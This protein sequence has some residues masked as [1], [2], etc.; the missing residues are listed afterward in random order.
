MFFFF[1][2]Y[3]IIILVPYS[4]LYSNKLTKRLSSLN[5]I[6]PV[7]GKLKIMLNKTRLIIQGSPLNH[8]LMSKVIYNL[9]AVGG[10]PSILTMVKKI[11]SISSLHSSALLI[12]GKPLALT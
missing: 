1:F 2:F 12:T 5:P 7:C 10:T 6:L 3:D 9:K 11:I 8:S 4:D